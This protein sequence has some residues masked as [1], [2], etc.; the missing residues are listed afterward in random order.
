MFEQVTVDNDEQL[1]KLVKQYRR[2]TTY[3]EARDSHQRSLHERFVA[4]A[5]R[6][7]VT[8]VRRDANTCLWTA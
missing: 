2:L 7:V 1:V 3:P 5:A 4:L 6:G 8:L